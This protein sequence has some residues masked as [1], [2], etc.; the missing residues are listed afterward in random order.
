MLGQTCT[1]CVKRTQNVKPST[2]LAMVMVEAVKNTH[3]FIATTFLFAMF[4]T[5]L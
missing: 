4:C 3:C 1:R 2:C 5:N